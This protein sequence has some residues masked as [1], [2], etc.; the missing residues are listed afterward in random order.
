MARRP[1]RVIGKTLIPSLDD[2]GRPSFGTLERAK[3]PTRQEERKSEVKTRIVPTREEHIAY[4]KLIGHNPML[5]PGE[6]DFIRVVTEWETNYRPYG[7]AENQQ[8]ERY[9]K[10]LQLCQA[11][12][13][14]S[15]SAS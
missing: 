2:S 10:E 1:S 8:L 9:R 13:H 3:T 5:I 11:M 6:P 7:H 12:N 15:S 4:L 14:T